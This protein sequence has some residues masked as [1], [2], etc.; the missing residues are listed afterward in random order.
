MD[1]TVRGSTSLAARN[2][3][4]KYYLSDISFCRNCMK[5]AMPTLKQFP[6]GGTAKIARIESGAWHQLS[7]YRPIRS[8]AKPAFSR[9]RELRGAPYDAFV[10]GNFQQ[11]IS[12]AFRVVEPIC[13]GSGRLAFC[14]ARA[15]KCAGRP[16]D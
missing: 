13:L 9:S 2:L 10:R 12:D 14:R 8:S 16:S 11:A 1:W 7:I 3:S 5:S 6:L 15:F 4:D